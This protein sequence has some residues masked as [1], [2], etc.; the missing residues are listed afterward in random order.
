MIYKKH[1]LD[2]NKGVV[3]RTIG[4]RISDF[5][6]IKKYSYKGALPIGGSEFDEARSEKKGIKQ[7]GKGVKVG[8]QST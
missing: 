1:K 6:N 3:L 4:Y 8:N 7:S 2:T 5:L